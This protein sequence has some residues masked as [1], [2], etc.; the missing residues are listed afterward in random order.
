MVITD[1]P[2]RREYYT[3]RET[4]DLC[5]VDRLTIRRWMLADKLDGERVGGT[6]LFKRRVV[7]SLVAGR[8]AVA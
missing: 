6:V 2:V 4:A 8:T 3:L 7:D 1:G 5:R